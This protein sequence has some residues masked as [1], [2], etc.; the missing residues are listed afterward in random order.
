MYK[1]IAKALKRAINKKRPVAIKNKP[2]PVTKPKTAC[3]YCGNL[4]VTGIGIKI[5]EGKCKKKVQSTS[6]TTTTK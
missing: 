6:S 3:Q 4:Y 1:P 5:H 2:K